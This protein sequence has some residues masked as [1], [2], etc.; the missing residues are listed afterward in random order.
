MNQT[1]L[2]QIP[3][4]KQLMIVPGA[5]HLFTEPGTLERVATLARDWFERYLSPL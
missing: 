1:A 2:E 4:P 5:T 3:A